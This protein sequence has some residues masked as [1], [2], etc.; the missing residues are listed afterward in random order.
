[1]ADLNDALP[2]GG[3]AKTSSL[4][5]QAA[6]VLLCMGEEPA[7][8]VLRCLS[9]EEL[10]EVTQVMSRL[11]GIKVDAVKTSMQRF[12]E[13]YRE[14]SGVHGA[15]RSYLKR[16][17]DLALGS[18][19][20]GNVLNSI[21]GDA[22][23]PKMARLQW[24]SPKWLADRI[25]HEH[26]R[27]QAVFLAFLPPTQASMVIEALPEASRDLVLLNM[28][29]LQEIE[30]ELLLE[31]E[32]IVARCLDEL[33]TQSAMVEGTRQVAEIINRLTGDKRQMV[34]LLRAHDPQVV[35]EIE[36]SMYDFFMLSNQTEEVLTRILDEVPLEQWAMAL[37]GAE[38]SVRNAILRA[39]PR[40]QAQSFEDL[41][42]RAG[43]V[44][45]SRVDQSRKEI[46]AQVK[47]LADAGEIQIQLFAETVVE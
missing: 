26:V 39:M 29:R 23:R 42:R 25:A 17:L 5:E 36:V 15:S 24:A 41:L 28:A 18:D 35:S 43:P 3:E 27:M 21:Y 44:P 34:E 19:I 32:E 6:I 12:F 38:P 14:Q 40:R 9:R 45:L 2:S 33:G 37:K 10:L 4:V 20:A 22:I 11:S 7:A 1:M 8:A 47:V 46:M 31:L 30:S 16:S 13:D